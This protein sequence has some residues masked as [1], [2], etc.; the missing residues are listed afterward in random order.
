[1]WLYMCDYVCDC[2]YVWLCVC[3][4]VYIYD[5]MCDYVYV[6]DCRCVLVLQHT[7]NYPIYTLNYPIYTLNYPTCSNFDP[8]DDNES[9]TSTATY[10]HN[11]PVKSNIDHGYVY[12]RC[13]CIY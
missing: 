9:T 13:D 8:Y 11:T 1:M 3:V 2:V 6:C 7:L 12:I 10:T 5:C 4:Y